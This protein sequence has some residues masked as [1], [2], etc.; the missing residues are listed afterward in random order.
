MK[1]DKNNTEKIILSSVLKGCPEVAQIK[2]QDLAE[3]AVLPS[4][5]PALAL[6]SQPTLRLTKS[7]SARWCYV[8]SSS[9]YSLVT[10]RLRQQI[11][12]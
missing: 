9:E 12:L 11:I 3:G 5:Y 8:G 1:E 7:C 2:P 6:R 4:V 10:T